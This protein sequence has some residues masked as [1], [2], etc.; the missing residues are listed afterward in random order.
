MEK[1]EKGYKAGGQQVRA[2]QDQG[3][4][5]SRGRSRG[6]VEEKERAVPENLLFFSAHAFGGK[7]K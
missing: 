5:L 7:K 3:K 2:R 4:G 1:R 6:K